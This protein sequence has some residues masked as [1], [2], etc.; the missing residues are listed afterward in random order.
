MAAVLYTLLVLTVAIASVEAGWCWNSQDNWFT[1]W[2]DHGCCGDAK[3]ACC[4]ITDDDDDGLT[5][6]DIAGIVVGSV[7]AVGLVICGIVLA[8]YFFTTCCRQQKT[9]LGF[10]FAN[11][12]RNPP[13]STNINMTTYPTQQP[14]VTQTTYQYPQQQPVQTSVVYN[15]SG[16]I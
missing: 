1:R 7:I 8:I 15:N 9:R 13:P 16:F 3:D 11:G 5:G 2:C 14:T 4:T 6:E 10:V 12:T